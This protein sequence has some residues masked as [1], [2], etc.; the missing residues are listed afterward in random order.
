MTYWGTFHL[1]W[2]S[3]FELIMIKSQKVQWYHVKDSPDL[4]SNTVTAYR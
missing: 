1:L 3:L 2:L 4:S